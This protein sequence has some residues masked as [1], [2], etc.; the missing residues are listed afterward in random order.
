MFKTRIGV[1]GMMCGQCESHVCELLRKIPGALVVKASHLRNLATILSPRP[2]GEEEAK[3][4]LEGSGYKLLSFA[5][6]ENVKEP[7]GYR[8]KLRKYAAKR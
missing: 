8:L 4:A 2:I 5:Q 6:E 7:L 3:K 1:D